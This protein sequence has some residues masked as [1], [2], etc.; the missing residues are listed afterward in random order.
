[1][2]RCRLFNC[3]LWLVVLGIAV[4]AAVS[5]SLA[6]DWPQWM[7]ANRDAKVSGFNAPETWPQELKKVWSVEVGNGVATPALVGGRLYVFARQ[8]DSEVTR[9]LDAKTGQELW[10][11]KYA[12]QAATGPAARFP[13]PRSSPTVADGQ[14]IVYGA[15]GKLSC[16][17]AASGKALWRKE[18]PADT[19]LPRFFTSSSPIVVAGL[20][21]AQR[22]GEESGST[23]AY[24]LS[25]GSQAWSWQGPGT[26]YAS[27]Q[28]VTIGGANT[29]IVE[30][31]EN[32]VALNATDGSVLWQMPYQDTGGRGA[33]NAATPIADGS[34]LVLNGTRRGAKALLLE[35]T[36]G[37]LATDELWSN[38]DNSVIYNTPILKD[39][40]LYGLS[41]EDVLFCVDT[42]TGKTTWSERV[43][44]GGRGSGY[45]SI[46]DAG[47]VLFTLTPAGELG[48]IEPNG[49][50]LVR[51]ANYRVAEDQTYAYPVID[52]QHI[53]IKDAN[54]VTLYSL[55]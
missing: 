41:A 46:V 43:G 4:S 19:K 35:A 3:W 5:N 17:D 38:N 36:G 16:L 28:L 23:V 11:D 51:L 12:A 44:E 33:Y 24:N 53:Y 22:G 14:V 30:S 9:C 47:T 40:Y 50:E 10:Q 20:C 48:V 13:G 29:V 45:G 1:M 54:S 31:D 26:A 18:E 6:D 39:G 34:T 15:S 52:G 25:D 7:G 8:G 2:T 49:Q 32:V 37:K 55:E 27:P 21:I 42:K